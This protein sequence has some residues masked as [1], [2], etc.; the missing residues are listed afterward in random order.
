[1]IKKWIKVSPFF[2][3]GRYFHLLILLFLTS[4]FSQAFCNTSETISDD[5][6]P[7]Q[8]KQS[9]VI[10]VS[11][12]ATIF[13]A[14]DTTLYGAEIVSKNS[15]KKQ[16]KK[17]NKKNK[18]IVKLEKKVIKIEKTKKALP[19]VQFVSSKSPHTLY[20]NTT[21]RK[22]ISIS[23]NLTFKISAI[24]EDYISMKIILPFDSNISFSYQSY[25]NKTLLFGHHFQ[26]PP[27]VI[28]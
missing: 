26:R 16:A 8:I 1:M 11:G 28:F 20:D 14:D 3:K 27:P 21:N 4:L 2:I 13:V 12:G 15:V 22:D 7:E 24:V 23:P 17:T 9:E 10:V 18:A 25:S 19:E 6:R 5:S